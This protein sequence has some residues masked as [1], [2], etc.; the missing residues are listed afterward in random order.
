MDGKLYILKAFRALRAQFQSQLL[1]VAQPFSVFFLNF[2]AALLFF[3][4][5]QNFTLFNKF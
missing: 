3:V 4:D 2:F 5:F 1:V